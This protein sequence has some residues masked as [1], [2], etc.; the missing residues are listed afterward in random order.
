[1]LFAILS[2]MNAPPENTAAP[3]NIPREVF[4]LISSTRTA[5]PIPQTAVTAITG[6]QYTVSNRSN[7][8]GGYKLPKSCFCSKYPAIYNT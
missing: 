5:N 4:F 6:T 2:T 7:V 8:S 3:I 1:M